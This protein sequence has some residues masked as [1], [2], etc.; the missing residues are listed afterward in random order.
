M[1]SAPSERAI[2]RPTRCP[3]PVTSTARPRRFIG[4]CDSAPGLRRAYR[5]TIVLAMQPVGRHAH[6]AERARAFGRTVP[7]RTAARHEREMIDERRQPCDVFRRVA[8]MSYLDAVE[9]FARERFD[10]VA[11]A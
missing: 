9:T 2:A 11:R 4:E 1:P 5:E 3:A 6:H 10:P 7:V 8:R